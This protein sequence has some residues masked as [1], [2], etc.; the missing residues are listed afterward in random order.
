MYVTTPFNVLFICGRN[1][2][3]SPTAER[4]FKNDRRMNVRAAGLGDTSPRRLKESDL[5]WAHLVL[6][7]ERKYITR[8]RDTF[9]K[10]DPLP[11]IKSLN[12]SDEYIFMQPALV[13]LLQI[14]VS[15]A[16]LEYEADLQATNDDAED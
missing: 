13:E 1:N 2:R 8:I 6:V 16:L 11:P 14:A 3:R 10:V 4:V 5:T 12:I 7:M 15:S 9:R